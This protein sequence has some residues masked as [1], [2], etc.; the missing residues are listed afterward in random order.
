YYDI[1]HYPKPI[2]IFCHGYKGFKDWGAWNLMAKTFAKNGFFFIKFNFSHNG[3]TPEEPIDFPDLASFAEDNFS[4]QLKD[5]GSVIDWI[6]TT[7]E[8]V[9]EADVANLN[10]IG[11]SRGG[12]IV[13]IKAAENKHVSRVATWAG[14]SD[15]ARAFPKGEKLK[16]WQKEGV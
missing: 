15:L 1:T 4:K 6:T 3:G 11:H 7:K 12:A 16:K 8:F 9:K 14:V 5:L 13:L 10:L 2:V